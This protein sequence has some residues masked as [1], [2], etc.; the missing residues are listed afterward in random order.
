MKRLSISI[1]ILCVCFVPVAWGQQ[2]AGKCYNSWAQFHRYNMQRWNRCE[3]VLN[4]HTVK[5]LGLKWSYTT[6]GGVYSSPAVA[7]GVVYV[8]SGDYKVYALNASTGALLWSYT[9]SYSVESSPAVANGVVYVGSFDSV[10]YGY[11]YALNASTGALLWSYATGQ[12]ESSPAVANGLV[13]IG[14]DEGFAVAL[15][16][17]TD[18]YLGWISWAGSQ[19]ESSPAVS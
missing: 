18:A 5:S 1:L 4:V 10:D 14:S 8:G 2:P 9:T 19:V 16:A 3:K 12:V 6:G 11:V 17:R 15:N 7:N 13:Y